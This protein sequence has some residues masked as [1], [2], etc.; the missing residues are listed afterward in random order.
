MKVIISENQLK[1]NPKAIKALVDEVG[2]VVAA[3]ILG[4]E[5]YEIFEKG[6]LETYESNIVIWDKPIKSLGNLRY[7][8]GH[9][10]IDESKIRS[11][12]K[13]EYV[14]GNLKV[15]YSPLES[16]GDLRLVGGDL[17]LIA[18]DVKNF[19][20]LESVGGNLDIRGTHLA[21]L[22]EREIRSMIN[23]GGEIYRKL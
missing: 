21:K 16:L 6:L 8:Y 9:I 5:P 10:Q 14:T 22:P 1:K 19:G 17:S 20:K 13:L 3:N 4:I 15:R 18:T 2:L 7:V 12:G 11:L 23:V